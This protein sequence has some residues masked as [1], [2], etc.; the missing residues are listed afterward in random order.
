MLVHILVHMLVHVLVTDMR[1]VPG[2]VGSN[3]HDPLDLMLRSTAESKPKAALQ[4]QVLCWWPTCA[5]K[6]NPTVL[7][8]ITPS[9]KA[10]ARP[11]LDPRLLTTC[12]GEMMQV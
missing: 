4:L 6:A 3:V 1:W 11:R 7:H 10:L 9:A 12:L 5:R 8:S 2:D